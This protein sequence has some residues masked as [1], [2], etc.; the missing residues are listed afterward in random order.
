LSYQ[1]QAERYTKN[2]GFI[3]LT[4]SVAFPSREKAVNADKA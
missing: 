2:R 3:Y 1:W 4:A